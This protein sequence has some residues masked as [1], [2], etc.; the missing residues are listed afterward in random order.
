MPAL[1]YNR[2][3]AYFISTILFDGYYSKTSKSAYLIVE[4]SEFKILSNSLEKL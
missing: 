4:Y 3:L 2:R 1:Q